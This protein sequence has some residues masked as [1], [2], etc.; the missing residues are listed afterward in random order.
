M[1]NFKDEVDSEPGVNYNGGR[2]ALGCR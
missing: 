1:E 2:A